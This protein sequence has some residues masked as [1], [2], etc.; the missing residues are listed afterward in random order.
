VALV[1][2]DGYTT[3]DTTTYQTDA[4]YAT[5]P[6]LTNKLLD[7]VTGAPGGNNLEV[8]LDIEMVFAMAPQAQIFVVEGNNGN[9]ILS[10]I[11]SP[12]P[13]DP[14]C[15]IVSCSWSFTVGTSGA[16]TIT[17]N[18][19]DALASQGQSY[20]QA[21]GDNGS[22]VGSNTVPG[23]IDLTSEMTVVGGTELTTT[24]GSP[25]TYAGETTWNTVSAPTPSAGG[26]GI[27][28]SS[29]PVPIPTYQIPFDSFNTTFGNGASNLNRNLPDV[30]MVAANIEAIA[31]NITTSGVTTTGVTY[32][33]VG[34]SAAA[35]L[36]AGLTALINEKA[37]AQ[38]PMGFMNPALY[39]LAQNFYSNDFNDINDGSN[40][41]LSGS[42]LY[43]AV[44][45]YDLATGLGSPKCNL[46]ADMINPPP[47]NT[48]TIT[49]TPTNTYTP[50][51]TPTPTNTPTPPTTA[52]SYAYP[53]PAH[54]G[55]VN[56][57]YN[58]P[59][60][61]QVRIN[62]YSVSGEQVDSVMDNPVDSNQNRVTISLQGFVPSVYF[63]VINGLT[64][65][66][67]AKGK[68]LV[69]P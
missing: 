12:Q 52:S 22:Y 18:L 8:A 68:F 23:P 3:S 27:C 32:S 65:G 58:S 38:G 16:D 15:H 31:T 17:G 33:I 26:G 21:A 46:I 66:V 9:D 39:F 69:V 20:F 62:I 14:L 4:G 19:I 40:N 61:Q 56:I 37:G 11:S 29:T 5:A 64:S 47:T 45:G 6:L 51:I 67:L 54:G 36:W 44:T 48:P 10:E 28:N 13:G 24:S 49:P 25:I 35:P 34:T 30:S 50:T 43:P 60:A 41:N 1:E 2:F 7:G 53:Q 59:V 55:Q 42:G 63:Y 57:C